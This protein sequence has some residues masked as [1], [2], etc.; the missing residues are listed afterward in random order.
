MD[1]FGLAVRIKEEGAAV[2]EKAVAKLKGSVKGLAETFP[3]LSKA[4]S[5]FWQGLT[6]DI[7]KSIGSFFALQGAWNGI[8]RVFRETSEAEESVAQL[9]AALEST[10]YAAGISSRQLQA[11]ASELQN[12]TRYGDDAVMAMQT[13][14][15]TFDRLNADT[16]PRAQQAAIDLAAR[17]RIDL[18]S[19]AKLV[20][21]ALQDPADGLTALKRV[22]V[23]FN[24]EQKKVIESFM[25][26]NRVAEAQ[27]VVL[28][29]LETKF[30]GAAVASRETL[31]GSLDYL[32]N[33]FGDLLELSDKSS[34]KLQT[35]FNFLGDVLQGWRKLLFDTPEEELVNLDAQIASLREV[36][37]RVRET[38]NT[39][40]E[41]ERKIGIAQ[42]RINQ[43]LR[44]A[45][46][47]AD[48]NKQA[49]TTTPEP[50]ID[51]EEQKLRWQRWEENNAVAL[52]RGQAQFQQ[53]VDWLKKNT[54]NAKIVFDIGFRKI[55]EQ[56]DLSGAG[57]LKKELEGISA[58]LANVK[59]APLDETFLDVMRV[60]EIKDT[61]A[62]GISSSIEGGFT[63]GIAAAISSGKI[64]D[65]WKAMGQSIIQNIANAMVQV[66][67]KAINFA[68]MLASIQKFMIAHP[69]LA[70]AAAVALLAFARANGGS[71]SASDTTMAGGA[72]GLTYGMTSGS[73]M[74]APPTPIVFGGT[75]AG[76]ASG[77]SPQPPMNF[78]IIG[79]NDPNAQRAI[80][81]LM[82]KADSRG[83]IG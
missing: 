78:N 7:G 69:V 31:A 17:Y 4:S 81:E 18:N 65:A 25:Q 32:N 30:K 58:E 11:W 64:S 38:S 23:T 79:P 41:A 45:R 67:L 72:S 61:L 75:S 44:D 76:T 29:N 80:Q 35:T 6:S 39:Y 20:G 8:M 37:K 5:T 36:Q 33:Q 15:L 63:S 77:I 60:D 50:V 27:A 13:V 62:G 68:K 70:I 43:I 22:G 26:T 73:P 55:A 1:V 16:F 56:A 51:E 14:L 19:A 82:R 40:Q 42:A 47:E 57:A 74:I 3:G 12:T 59:I 49:S 21:K 28:T 71:S 48:R 83:R 9:N 34:S 2:V 54:E 10:G 66:A 46:E 53:Y 24:E 52:K